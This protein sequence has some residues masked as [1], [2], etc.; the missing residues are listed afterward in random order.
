MLCTLTKKTVFLQTAKK[1][2][3]QLQEMQTSTDNSKHKITEGEL[4]DLIRNLELPKN[5][6]ELLASRLQH[7]NL[8]HH[9]EKATTF[10]TIK[11]E[12]EQFFKNV[13]YFTYWKNTDGLMDA[14][15]MRHR[16]EQWRLFTVVT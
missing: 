16:P 9:S 4:N 2:S 8:Q 12:F 6:A 11:Q 13:G 7:W 15:H 1:S 5:K 3:H 14:K 10:R